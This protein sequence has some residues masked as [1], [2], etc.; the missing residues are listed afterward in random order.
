MAREPIALINAAVAAIQASIPLLVAFGLVQLSREQ[1]GAITSA[2]AAWAGLVG[3]Y[4]ARSLVTP[5][6]NPKDNDGRSLAP[7]SESVNAHMKSAA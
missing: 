3:T 4:V 2:V 7:V 1:S 5:V 6:A